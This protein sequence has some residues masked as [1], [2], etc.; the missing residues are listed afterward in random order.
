MADNG[1]VGDRIIPLLSPIEVFR[2]KDLKTQ[3]VVL[4]MR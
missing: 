3:L 2:L 4:T 1:I